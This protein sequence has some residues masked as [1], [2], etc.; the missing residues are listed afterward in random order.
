MTGGKHPLMDVTGEDYQEMMR[1]HKRRKLE[2][3][4]SCGKII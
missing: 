4:V 2:Y 3:P 1:K